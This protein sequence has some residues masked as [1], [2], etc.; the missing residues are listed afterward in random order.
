[1]RCISPAH[2]ESKLLDSEIWPDRLGI[3]WVDQAGQ[4]HTILRAIE[5]SCV[6]LDDP[7]L[8]PTV[9]PI[10]SYG[11]NETAQ[12]STRAQSD[13][14][15]LL[16]YLDQFLDLQAPRLEDQQFRDA[17]LQNQTDIEKAQVQVAR[18]PDYKKLLANVQ[19]QLKTLESAQ[20]Q[21]VV[22]LER[23]VAEER[24]IRENIERQVGQVSG[25][26]K[27]TS[28]SGLLGSLQHLAVADQLKVGSEEYKKIVDLAA[29][30]EAAA[31]TS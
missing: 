8:G 5:E 20:A 3:V 23:R 14:R 21:E 6:N 28:V 19:Q 13:P 25:Q 9:F 30:F 29:G 31:K 18:I 27:T 7:D 24:T 22:A 2:S 11:Q 15:A 17:L 4:Q 26:V 16:N 12:T 1:V 10:E